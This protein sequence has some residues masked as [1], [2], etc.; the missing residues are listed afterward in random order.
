MKKKRILT[1]FA[2]ILIAVL[3]AWRLWPHSL[4]SILGVNEEAFNT[5]TITVS[6][7][8]IVNHSPNIDSYRLDVS[9]PND[10][11]YVPVMSIIQNTKFRSDFRNLLPWDI[12]SVGSG[13]KN[14][15]HSANMMLTWGDADDVAHISF[16]GDRVV[17]FYISGKTEYL[18]YHPTNRT[19]LN[20][21]A[22]YIKE[23]SVFQS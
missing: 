10:D 6:E 19:I 23:N 7:F 2:A 3:C 18:V 15:T 16:H 14:I 13:S 8:G 1:T 12:L 5:I 9:S 17:S 4:K 21:I 11:N 22:T 20:E